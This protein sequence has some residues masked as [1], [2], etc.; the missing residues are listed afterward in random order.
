M[1]TRSGATWSQQA[2][3][4]SSNTGSNDEFGY[5]LGLATDGTL[6]VGAPGEAS[7][8]TGVGGNQANNALC[9]PA[10]STCCRRRR[11]DRTHG[12]AGRASFSQTGVPAG[13]Q[14][15]EGARI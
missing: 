7:A 12:R 5:S 13:G 4:K 11:R 14:G 8:A 2:Y 1:F 10:R 6:A 15:P 3:V 9:S